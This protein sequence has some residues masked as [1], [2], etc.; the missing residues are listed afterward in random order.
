MTKISR[1]EMRKISSMASRGEIQVDEGEFLD[2][3]DEDV[4]SDDFSDDD[5]YYSDSDDYDD[6]AEVID[7]GSRRSRFNSK[8]RKGGMRG[9]MS[10]NPRLR[11][12]FCGHGKPGSEEYERNRAKLGSR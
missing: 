9:R 5:D 4:F 6:D 8:G 12:K 10:N 7:V 1:A 11:R 3:A 2:E